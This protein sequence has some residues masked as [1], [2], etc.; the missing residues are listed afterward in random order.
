MKTPGTFVAEI[1]FYALMSVLV[2]FGWNTF[3]HD[4]FG[5][6]KISYVSSLGLSALVWAVQSMLE[7]MFSAIRASIHPHVPA[8]TPQA[9]KQDTSSDEK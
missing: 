4:V 1:F 2:Y 7:A 3:L 5:A 9:T 6:V 8:S